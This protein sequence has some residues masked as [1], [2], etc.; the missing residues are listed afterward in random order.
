[1]NFTAGMNLTELDVV[2]QVSAPALTDRT[3]VSVLDAVENLAASDASSITVKN[4]GGTEFTLTGCSR[5]F[6]ITVNCLF[7]PASRRTDGAVF[8][9]YD[10]SR[11]N[12]RAASAA[13]AVR[14]DCI[15]Y[16]GECS[17]LR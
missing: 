14:M 9:T 1:M 10:F 17:I 11:N 2:E 12:T 5:D 4:S 7:R 8:S 16:I 3:V 15:R 13:G 6:Y